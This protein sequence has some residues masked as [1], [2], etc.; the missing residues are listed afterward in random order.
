MYGKI[1]GELVS[2]A[3]ASEDC[4]DA[5]SLRNSGIDP[6][7]VGC[8]PR[9]V[10]T[11]V[12]SGL[13]GGAIPNTVLPGLGV[14]E[15]GFFEQQ[16][17]DVYVLKD[18]ITVN[19]ESF[20]CQASQSSCYNA[21]KEYFAIGAAGEGEMDDVCCTILSKVA[22]D[23]EIEQSDA[24]NRICQDFKEGT[25]PATA[26]GTLIDEVQAAIDAAP[27]KICAGFA[28]GT[29]TGTTVAP[30]CEGQV[31]GCAIGTFGTGTGTIGTSESDTKR[32][33]SF[34]FA[35][36]VAGMTSVAMTW[37]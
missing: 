4:L 36:L 17:T 5:Y 16:G 8:D 27:D 25:S 21:M 6:F 11:F 19:G 24:R 12:N 33:I 9:N 13:S 2:W 26:C 32:N 28:F 3:K 1:E 10:N 35:M 20:D 14:A 22:L 23:N 37:T 34:T 29:G 15:G 18:S 30:G 31:G 7:S